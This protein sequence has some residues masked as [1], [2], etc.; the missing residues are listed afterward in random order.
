MF[1]FSVEKIRSVYLNRKVDLKPIS[2]FRKNLAQLVSVVLINILS[3]TIGACIG[4]VIVLIP[5][6]QEENSKIR[7]PVH[8]LTWIST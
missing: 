7:V 5:Y 8:E 3:L 2:S 6:L 1:C 4:F